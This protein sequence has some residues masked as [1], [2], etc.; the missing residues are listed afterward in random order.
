MQCL[1]GRAVN[2]WSLYCAFH[3]YRGSC[4][5][6]L[7]RPGGKCSHFCTK[8]HNLVLVEGWWRSSTGKA[9]WKVAAANHWVWC[10]SGWLPV[11]GS[12]LDPMDGD[13]L[14]LGKWCRLRGKQC[15][16]G[17]MRVTCK[18]TACTGLVLD[19]ITRLHVLQLYCLPF[20]H[21]HAIIEQPLYLLN[22]HTSASC[23]VRTLSAVC[24]L[25]YI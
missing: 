6:T 21:S 13:V 24:F 4:V 10:K 25:C 1:N 22:L 12:V 9:W 2:L 19:P 14:W 11:M 23:P 3:S 15:A 17:M 18:V 7:G 20:L 5:A 8:Q 16:T